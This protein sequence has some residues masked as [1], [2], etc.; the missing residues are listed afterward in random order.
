MTPIALRETT[1][2][3]KNDQEQVQITPVASDLSL[4][5]S[6]TNLAPDIGDT[7]RFQITVANG[8][9]STA[10]RVQVQDQFANR[11]AILVCEF[12]ARKRNHGHAGL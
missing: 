8:G 2:S 1:L 4:T 11:D 5:K 12:S 3:A 6:V 7:V 9:P 10:T